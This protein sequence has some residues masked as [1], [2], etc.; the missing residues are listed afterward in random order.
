[1]T[2]KKQIAAAWI[3]SNI[4]TRHSLV[5]VLRPVVS[6]EVY[7]GFCSRGKKGGRGEGFPI[8]SPKKLS[9]IRGFWGG[10]GEKKKGYLLVS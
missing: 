6:G 4:P 5:Q 7:C 8:H 3:V 1:M 10:K 9:L 2:I